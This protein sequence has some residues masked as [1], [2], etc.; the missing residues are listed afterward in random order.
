[1]LALCCT[2]R[3]E[4]S[5]LLQR[6]R[7]LVPHA[8]WMGWGL[9]VGVRQGHGGSRGAPLLSHHSG[10]AWRHQPPSCDS[11]HQLGHAIRRFRT[12]ARSLLFSHFCQINSVLGCQIWELKVLVKNITKWSVPGWKSI[13]NSDSKRAIRIAA[14][15]YFFAPNVM[16]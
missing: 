11:S 14:N 4:I 7:D 8:L 1:M 5:F 2:S 9:W 15:W 12:L 3:V 6:V 13:S 10:Q 16:N